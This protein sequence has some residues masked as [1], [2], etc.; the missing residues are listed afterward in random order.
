MAKYKDRNIEISSENLLSW[1]AK[2]TK[3]YELIQSVVVADNLVA[4]KKI[5]IKAVIPTP[6][7]YPYVSFD[8]VWL[9]TDDG[10]TIKTNGIVVNITQQYRHPENRLRAG[11]IVEYNIPSNFGVAFDEE[12]GREIRYSEPMN[13]YSEFDKIN[14]QGVISNNQKPTITKV[15]EAS[16]HRVKVQIIEIEGDAYEG[17]STLRSKIL[18]TSPK[19]INYNESKLVEAMG[20]TRVIREGQ[21]IH[22]DERNIFGQITGAK[23]KSYG[24]IRKRGSVIRQIID[25]NGNKIEG[26]ESDKLILE[27]VQE[28]TAYHVEAPQIEGYVFKRLA[29]DSSEQK[30]VVEEGVKNVILVY[31]RPN[32]QKEE[33]KSEE[34]QAPNTGFSGGI[35]A[36]ALSTLSLLGTATLLVRKR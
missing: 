18:D 6:P 2:T 25:E 27:R 5:Q 21:E 29:V 8:R 17:L 10:E 14:P 7:S 34:I 13:T 1:Q 24:Q 15:I 30:G 28:G 19:T 32:I 26:L 20:V 33:N 16:P 22:K 9:S 12:V 36:L 3:D 23:M 11:D 4:S 31:G 35:S